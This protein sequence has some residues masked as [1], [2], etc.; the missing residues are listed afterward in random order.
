VLAACDPPA[1]AQRSG[2]SRPAGATDGPAASPVRPTAACWWSY[3]PRP[4]DRGTGARHR[5]V[6]A[7]G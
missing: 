3:Q 7:G 6:S 1:L 4:P 2:P 5:D